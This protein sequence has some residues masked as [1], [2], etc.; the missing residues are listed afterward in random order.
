MKE[1]NI[2]LVESSKKKKETIKEE[3]STTDYQFDV[4]KNIYEGRMFDVTEMS[5]LKKVTKEAK[6]VTAEGLGKRRT[7]GMLMRAQ[8]EKSRRV[9][10]LMLRLLRKITK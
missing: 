6:K 8:V 1:L 7:K 2:S 3:V 9:L 4:N 10:L 5:S